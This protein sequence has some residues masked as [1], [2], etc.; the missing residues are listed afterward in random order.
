MKTPGEC[1]TVDESIVAFRGR[2]VFTQYIPGNRHKYGIKLFKL[3]DDDGFTL[4]LT[5]KRVR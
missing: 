4:D 3:C 1:I 5:F 2:I